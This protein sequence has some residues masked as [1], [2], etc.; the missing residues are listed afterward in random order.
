MRYKDVSPCGEAIVQ[1]LTK[2]YDYA[3]LIE[4]EKEHY[5]HIEITPDLKEGGIHAS[6]AWQ[7]YWER[8]ARVVRTSEFADIAG[9]LSR[10]CSHLDRPVEVLSLGSGYCGNELAL[11]RRFT[12]DYRIRCTDINEKL[13]ERARAVA[14][15]ERLHVEFGVA[16]LNFIAIEPG[17]YDLIFA[18]AAIHHV[19]NVEHLFE[20]L[21]GGLSPGGVFHLVDVVGKNR[22]L[23]W[24]ESEQFANALLEL[25]PRRLTRGVRLE[26][27]DAA[28][29]M[30][31]I[32][33]QDIVPGLRQSFTPLFEHRH[34]AFM[35]FIC[36]HPELGP[37]LDPRDDEAR[38]HLDF[39]ID[40]DDS[41]V[42][43]GVLAPL[44]IWGVYRTR[45]AA[46][47]SSA[48]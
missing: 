40:C 42:R 30:E 14:R 5:S 25:V 41:A 28:E 7:Y 20:Q 32:R 13:F 8:V 15:D 6:S 11:A 16:D 29:G 19:I 9:Y 31:G 12:H 33:Q 22:K 1:D 46:G 27:P 34:G 26:V 18:H 48:A 17:R 38:R 3:K 21:V 43:H 44:E 36:T 2:T 45:G 24:D 37:A 4:E 39:L 47:G 23:I 10:T 35:R